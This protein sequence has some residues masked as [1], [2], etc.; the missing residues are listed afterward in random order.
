MSKDCCQAYTPD[1]VKAAILGELICMCSTSRW[2]PCILSIKH[3]VFQQFSVVLAPTYR[4][5]RMRSVHKIY[6][7]GSSHVRSAADTCL[8]LHC[9]IW[10]NTRSLNIFSL[11]TALKNKHKQSC[12]LMNTNKVKVFW[13]P[14]V[15]VKSQSEMWRDFIRKG[16]KRQYWPVFS[17]IHD[18]QI[19]RTF[20]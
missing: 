18:K 19:H 8:F 20:D 16:G 1:G 9:Y 12:F 17:C 6:C 11:Q 4:L 10:P 15:S 13:L 5:I 2:F 3:C 14:F 7:D